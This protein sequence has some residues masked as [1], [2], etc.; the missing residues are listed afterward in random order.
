MK[1]IYFRWIQSKEKRT[2][3]AFL[4]SFSFKQCF[5]SVPYSLNPDPDPAILMNPFSGSRLLPNLDP[6]Q[7]FLKQRNIFDQKRN[8]SLFKPLQRTFELQKSPPAQQRTLQTRSFLFFIFW[9]TSLACPDPDSQSGFGSA[10]TFEFGCNPH[11]KHWFLRDGWIMYR[12][13]IVLC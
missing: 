13:F 5:R 1:Y 12:R 9:G 7:G 3:E 6:D 10:V 4:C 2:G 8:I 11:P